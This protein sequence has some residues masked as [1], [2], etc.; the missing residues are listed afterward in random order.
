ME[1]SHPTNNLRCEHEGCDRT[2][3]TTFNLRRH[4]KQVHQLQV[5][6]KC[7]YCQKYLSSKQNLKDHLNTHTGARPYHCDWP[8]CKAEFRQLSLFYLHKQLHIE[9]ENQE[10][11]ISA[12]CVNKFSFVKK[13]SQDVLKETHKLEEIITGEDLILQPIKEERQITQKLPS[14]F[15]YNIGLD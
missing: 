15:R 11:A 1:I 9:L 8:N 10:A 12:S 5:K 13:L 2:F 14:F 3:T 6:F 4:I 7:M